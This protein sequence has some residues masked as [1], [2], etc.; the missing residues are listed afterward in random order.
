VGCCCALSVSLSWGRLHPHVKTRDLRGA[1]IPC[2]PIT[3]CNTS[4]TN[5]KPNHTPAQTKPNQTTPLHK[6]NSNQTTHPPPNP[7]RLILENLLKYGI[8]LNLISYIL[9]GLRRRGDDGRA[10][11]RLFVL[12]CFPSLVAFSL[13]ALGIER[14]GLALLRWEDKVGAVVECVLRRR[15]GPLVLGWGL[16][17]G[18]SPERLTAV[19]GLSRREGTSL[20][21]TPTP[22]PPTTANPRRRKQL[23]SGLPK[24][25]GKAQTRAAAALTARIRLHERIL[26]A[27]NAANTTAAMLVPC[28]AVHATQVSQSARGGGCFS[29]VA[30]GRPFLVKVEALCLEVVGNSCLQTSLQS[31]SN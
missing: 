26:F 1:L 18:G 10:N 3:P 8:R 17:V 21:T 5:L 30:L 19:C 14:L 25:E 28:W 29:P 12:L 11:E 13:G 24:K 16:G 22:H 2:S 20:I 9:N 15:M 31:K 6:A 4:F 7:T 27:L 23:K